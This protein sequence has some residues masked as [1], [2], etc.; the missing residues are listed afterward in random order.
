MAGSSDSAKASCPPRWSGEDQ[1]TAQHF[2]NEYFAPQLI[3][4]SISTEP[5]QIDV[6]SKLFMP[7]VAGNPFTTAAVEMALWDIAGKI[8]GKPVYPLLGGKVRDV[9]PTKWSISGREPDIAAQIARDAASRGFVKMKV[10]V[11]ID[12]EGDV[13]RVRAVREAVGDK[14]VLG[15][16][17]NGGWKSPEIAIAVVNRLTEYQ[18]DFVEQPV[19]AFD[20]QG[21][22]KGAIR[23]VSN[24]RR[25]KR[26][27]AARRKES[28]ACG[29]RGRLLDLRG[30]G[31][32][33]RAG[34]RDICNF[35]SKPASPARSAATSKWVSAR[36]P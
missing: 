13:A 1:F 20:L 15:V 30:Q 25:R 32:R 26:L 19:T 33:H 11:G 35:G 10:K 17:A 18:I 31:R 3:G 22:A 8:A 34:A 14:I 16:D 5:K 24:H 12:A 27:H 2:I 36:L 21:M 23:K 7:T 28:V 6:L 9:V 29:S 4:Q